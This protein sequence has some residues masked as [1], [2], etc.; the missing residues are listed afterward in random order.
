MTI[1]DINVGDVVI[2]HHKSLAITDNGLV[3]FMPEGIRQVV[4]KIEENFI[5]CRS[6]IDFDGIV[7]RKLII[8]SVRKV[9]GKP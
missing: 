6:S 9:E 4:T 3:Y 5:W 8:T 2:T 7:S 1:D